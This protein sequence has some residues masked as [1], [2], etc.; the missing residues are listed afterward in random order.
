MVPA[1]RGYATGPVKEPFN[2]LFLGSDE[3][4]IASLNA[5]LAHPG[6]ATRRDERSLTLD[7]AVVFDTDCDIA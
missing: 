4:S 7:R 1:C 3:F 2:V 5:L 6:T